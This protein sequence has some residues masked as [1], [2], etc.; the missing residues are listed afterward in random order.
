MLFIHMIIMIVIFG[1]LA[2]GNG[3][4]FAAIVATKNNCLALQREADETDRKVWYHGDY[5]CDYRTNA[6]NRSERYNC[7][8][9]NPKW[10]RANYQECD[11][12]YGGSIFASVLL[13][14]TII[15]I[16]IAWHFG[17]TTYGR[18]VLKNIEK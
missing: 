7:R 9:E 2:Y 10:V 5:R 13:S 11:G 17:I 14:L 3:L 4:A 6:Q 1:A 8:F 16:F 12:N 18:Y 15:G